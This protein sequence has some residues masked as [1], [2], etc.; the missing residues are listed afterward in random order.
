MA[1][2]FE[3]ESSPYADA[4]LTS[5]KQ[6]KAFVP[7]LWTLEVANVLLMA[8]RKKRLQE[9]DILHFTHL[10]SQLPIHISE[11]PL[12]MT[13]IILLGQMHHLTSYDACYLGLAFINGLP[14]ATLDE[15]LK[16]AATKAGISLYTP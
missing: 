6:K 5:L 16:N 14:L 9:A 8:E 2:C 3:D 12:V 15:K 7:S 11:A 13:D 1:W 10:I 4:V